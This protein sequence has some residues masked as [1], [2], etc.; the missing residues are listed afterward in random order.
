M[1]G[2][3]LVSLERLGKLAMDVRI[4][5]DNTRKVHHLS[6]THDAVPCHHLANFF[7]TDVRSRILESCN[8]RYA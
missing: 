2:Y 5:V 8:S 6:K 7:R 1:A 3:Y 4:T